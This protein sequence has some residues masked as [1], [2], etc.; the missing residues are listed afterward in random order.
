MTT[1]SSTDSTTATEPN[2]DT[3]TS[4]TSATTT[5]MAPPATACADYG[6]SYEKTG[7]KFTVL[8]DA[9]Y[10]SDSG[11]AY[12][13]VNS[14]GDCLDICASRTDCVGL[15]FNH[16][17]GLC[18]IITS[19]M[20]QGTTPSDTNHAAKVISRPAGTSVSTTVAEPVP[21]TVSTTA[22]ATPG[23]TSCSDLGDSYT[24]DN[25][26][27]FTVKC[28]Y[29]YIGLE[30]PDPGHNSLKECMNI[31][32]S[33]ADCAATNFQRLAGDYPA[34]TCLYLTSSDSSAGNQRAMDA[35]AVTF[36]PATTTSVAATVSDLELNTERH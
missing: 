6:G 4:F 7:V 8:C 15:N 2:T 12:S 19:F 21:T 29:I 33:R 36:R 27:K 25:S 20:S 24:A 31:C 10:F 14:V 28:N 11:S 35:A 30:T 1:A 32:A 26:V 17:A 9:V 5:S 3:I 23:P 18:S 13:I 34:G 16:E 22:S